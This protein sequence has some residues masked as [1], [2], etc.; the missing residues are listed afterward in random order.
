M[1]FISAGLYCLAHLSWL[2][3]QQL[4]SLAKWA[5]ASMPA[6]SDAVQTADVAELQACSLTGRCGLSCYA[7]CFAGER[8]GGSGVLHCDSVATYF[9]V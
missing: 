6:G 2:N 8:V 9:L 3:S 7:M 1:S 5:F 4:D